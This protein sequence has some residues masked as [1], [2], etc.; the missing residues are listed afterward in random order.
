MRRMFSLGLAA[1]ALTTTLVALEADNSLGTRKVNIAASRS[2]PTP[3][4]VKSLTIVREAFPGGVKV[5][6]TGERTDGSEISTHIQQITM[7]PQPESRALDHRM[8]RCQSR[9]MTPILSRRSEEHGWEVFRHWT[10]RDLESRQDDDIDG[11]GYG[12]RWKGDDTDTRLRQA[13][14][15]VKTGLGK[16]ALVR[17]QLDLRKTGSTFR[18]FGGDT[19]I[20]RHAAS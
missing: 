1:L 3:L 5:T 13:A 18:E 14:G 20:D 6:T 10:H 4:P 8:T 9:R 16:K 15:D 19:S 17:L 11:Q 12:R 7:A 2:T